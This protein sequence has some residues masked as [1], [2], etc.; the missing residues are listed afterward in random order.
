ME[1]SSYFRPL[2]KWWWLIVV[3]GLVAAISS[4]VVTR[5]LPV[6]YESS[7][8]L[9]VGRAVYESNPNS[10]DFYLNQQLASFYADLALREPVRRATMEALGMPWL[11]QYNITALPNSLLIQI[12][13]ADT[14]PLRTQA[15]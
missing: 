3:A 9:V 12:Q 4:F 6:L 7:T 8:T 10:G 13:V 14:D 11:P 2:I 15:V 5:Q 1:L